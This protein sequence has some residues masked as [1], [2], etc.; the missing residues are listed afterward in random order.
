MALSSSF[1]EM[2]DLIVLLAGT[3]MASGAGLL[4]W[5]ILVGSAIGNCVEVEEELE[6]EDVE[7]DEELEEH[8]LL[9]ESESEVTVLW[10]GRFPPVV[11]VCV[12]CEL[13]FV[14]VLIVCVFVCLWIW[15][16]LVFMS[17]SF[18]TRGTIARWRCS[19]FVDIASSLSVKR[20]DKSL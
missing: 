11:S 16:D 13:S 18:A 3:S 7:E 20:L 6:D 1:W 9:S 19:A 8:V 17:V 12:S 2:V 5:L 4:L 15:S 10:L 14:C